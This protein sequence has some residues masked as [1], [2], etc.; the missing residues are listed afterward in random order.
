MGVVRVI[1][2]VT[3]WNCAGVKGGNYIHLDFNVDN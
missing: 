3:Q 2:K 1:E